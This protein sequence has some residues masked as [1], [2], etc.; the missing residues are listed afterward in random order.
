M[1]TRQSQSAG[2]FQDS[3]FPDADSLAALRGWYGGLSSRAAIARYLPGRRASGASSRAMLGR[4]RRKLIAFAESR[5]RADLVKVFQPIP[6]E[7]HKRALAVGR[8]I[9]TLRSLP[10]PQPQISDDVALWLSPR[11][12][13]ALQAHGIR[14]LADLTVRIPRRQRWWTTI[15]GLGVTTARQIET[16]FAAHLQL[17]E[18][19]RS[20]IAVAQPS[21][22]VPWEQLRLPHE[23]DGSQGSYRAPRQACIL[24]AKND[25]E[26]VQAWLALHETAATQRAYRKEAERLI[27]WAIVERQSALSSLTT[28]DAIAYRAFLRRPTPR[29]RWV[30]PPRSRASVEWRPF[31]G[32]LSAR[33]A[34]Y[35]LT[36][37]SAMFRWLIE[38][39]YVLANPF[40]GIKVRGHARQPALDTDRGFTEGEWHGLRALADDLE[41]AYGWSESA[42]QRLRFLLDFGYA[43]GLRASELVNAVLG[44][45]RIDERHDHWLQVTGK[46]GKRGKVALPTLARSALDQYLMH[47]NLSVTPTLWN[48]RTP[49]VGSLGEDGHAGIAGA[50]LW[51]VMRRFFIQVADVIQSDHPA[52]AEKLRR[53]SPHWMRH[54][55]ASHALARGAELTT[56]RDNLRHASI[57]TT[58]MYLHGDEIQRAWQMNQAFAVRK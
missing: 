33:S 6:D 42:A 40:A 53:A 15:S 18:C 28:D 2:Y 44:D 9:E 35:S 12:T 46:G 1:K 17:T 45:I 55:H 23:I 57:A 29:E 10:I 26:A 19:A 24:N 31:T 58:S 5:H 54:S 51:R 25:Y 4:I 56:V 34:S 48:P 20:L 7:R 37:L 11:A 13:R 52:L 21:R 49:L 8:A 39:R 41:C 47:R 14:T 32:A 30:G 27:L 22:L 36:V 43:T 16:F 3:S 38:Q 50:R